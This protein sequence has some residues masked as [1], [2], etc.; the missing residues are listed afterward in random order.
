MS[1]G[2][3]SAGL[4]I[5][6]LGVGGCN[7]IPRQFSSSGG[8]SGGPGGG[9]GG[10]RGVGPASGGT[11]GGPPFDAAVGS[12]DAGRAGGAGGGAGSMAGLDAGSPASDARSSSAPDFG[13]PLPCP[14][15][16]PGHV[17]IADFQMNTDVAFRQATGDPVSGGTFLDPLPS[18]QQDF[19]SDNW[20]LAG[21]VAQ[22]TLLGLYW[23]CQPYPSACALDLSRYQGIQFTLSGDVG[24]MGITFAMG[25][26]PDD[27]RNLPN[28]CGTCAATDGRDSCVDPSITFLPSDLSRTPPVIR[29]LWGSLEGGRPIPSIDPSRVTGIGWILP[30]PPTGETYPVDFTLDDIQ[31]IPYVGP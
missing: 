24:P 28:E 23:G 14:G 2:K 31:L 4:L 30:A 8:S 5:A 18:L 27:T 25:T 21:S 12:S 10:T 1:R 20:H 13:P 22:E 29:L 3:L 11:A 16:D 17:V 9:G 19:L 7:V 15:F 6:A 26:I